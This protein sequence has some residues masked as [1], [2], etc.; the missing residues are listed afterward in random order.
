[1]IGRRF[2]GSD[3]VD[4]IVIQD[5]KLNRGEY[6]KMEDNW[7]NYLK[8]TDENGEQKY[9]VN[10]DIRCKCNEEKKILVKIQNVRVKYVFI[11]GLRI[12]KG[13]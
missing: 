7:E 10:V 6:K 4:N 9:H 8:K 5:S 2:D 11:P 12:T 3:E 13:M 1:M